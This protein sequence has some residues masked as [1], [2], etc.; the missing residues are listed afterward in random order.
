LPEDE[1]SLKSKYVNSTKN[2]MNS[3]VVEIRAFEVLGSVEWQLLTDVSG[4]PV[5]LTF[6]GQA[7]DPC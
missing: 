5:G 7:V 3:S 4:Q 6:M 2:Y 1:F